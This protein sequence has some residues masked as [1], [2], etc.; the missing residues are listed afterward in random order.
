[1]VLAF[2]MSMMGNKARSLQ[3]FITSNAIVEAVSHT[4]TLTD[5]SGDFG[6]HG[7]ESTD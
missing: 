1:M 2:E 3:V 5:K 7:I 6:V 4:H